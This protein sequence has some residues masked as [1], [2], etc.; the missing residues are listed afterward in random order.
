MTA[1]ITK[2]L[3]NE[4]ARDM[5]NDRVIIGDPAKAIAAWLYRW[6]VAHDPQGQVDP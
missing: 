1:K 4:I 6:F 3:C 2:K 5:T